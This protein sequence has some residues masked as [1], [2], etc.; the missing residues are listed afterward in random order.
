MILENARKVYVVTNIIIIYLNIGGCAGSILN[1]VIKDYYGQGKHI[2]NDVIIL[3]N[4]SSVDSIKNA[5]IFKFY[6]PVIAT[7]PI[8]KKTREQNIKK[9]YNRFRDENGFGFDYK[10][11][12]SLK[13][14][15]NPL[16]YNNIILYS[17]SSKQNY[18]RKVPGLINFKELINEK[19]I[20][21]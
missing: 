13:R 21:F 7:D 1:P 14:T 4:I 15:Q 17:D 20:N 19:P 10:I 8:R 9:Y 5:Y 18:I 3:V 12:R 11:I 16:M 2:K 6:E